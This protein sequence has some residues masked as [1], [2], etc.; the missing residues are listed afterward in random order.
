MMK[1]ILVLMLTIAI[2]VLSGLQASAFA[3]DFPDVPYTHINYDAIMRLTKLGVVAG[4]EDGT[5]GP[6]KEI[7]RTE[8]CALMSRTL[9]YDKDTYKVK[10]I[11]FSDV[12]ENYW[13][14]AYISFCYEKGLVN[15]M[16]DNL[17]A[18]A[19]K[20][21][22]A[23]VVKMVVCAA[24]RENEASRHTGKLWYSGYM[25]VAELY[26]LL[27]ENNQEP[28]DNAFRSNAAQLVYNLIESGLV[29]EAD[30]D[31]DVTVEEPEQ[32][33]P[34]KDETDTEDETNDDKTESE[35]EENAV[36]E[37]EEVLSELEKEY[38]QKDF[39]DV[40]VILVD[41][42]HNYSGKDIGARIEEKELKEEIITWEIADR[43][44]KKLEKMGYTVV[45][46]REEVTDNIEP[47]SQLES[48][49]ARVD[50][51]HKVSADLF[52]SI[53]CN[54][55]GGTGTETYCFKPGGYSERLAKLVQK[56]ITENTGLRDRGVKN[57]NFYVIKNTLMPA[58]LVETAFMDNESDTEVITSAKGQELIAQ[59]IADS[60][61]KY[62]SMD[63]L[64]VEKSVA[65]AENPEKE[66]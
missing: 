65:D 56:N 24:E 58:I 33:K 30:T 46:T 18:P 61:K 4:Y 29:P 45:M 8:F 59:A 35:D 64:V 23:Q 62:D 9:G 38:A 39:S 31:V 48:L 15:G 25:K 49:Q 27:A 40:K 17:F 5:F 57:A 63:P 6:K 13:G 1:K 52:I 51:A 53:H 60:V 22:V 42:G 36:D 26:G 19:D 12:P 47:A 41:A 50:L 20:V 11:P 14:R 32:D 7:T 43:L 66:E 10:D 28:G 55:G 54:M 2:I 21:T 34:V 37:D 16:G 3:A 44:R